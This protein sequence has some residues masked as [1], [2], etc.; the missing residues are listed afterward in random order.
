MGAD[1]AVGPHC[2]R[3]KRSASLAERRSS[4][5]RCPG[6]GLK[7]CLPRT[8]P[9]RAKGSQSGSGPQYPMPDV[10]FR[11]YPATVFWT[12]PLVGAVFANDAF[13]QTFE[14]VLNSCFTRDFWKWIAP[15]PA[16]S[17]GG[18]SHQK[19]V[20]QSGIGGRPYQNCHKA[21]DKFSA[22][23]RSPKLAA[24]NPVHRGPPPIHLKF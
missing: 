3:V 20:A 7:G 17:I 21:V 4:A 11:A 1:I 16:V 8:A 18:W 6:T 14:T 24:V 23:S 10:H 5:R 13:Q 19:R 15:F 9:D 12:G 2:R 22:C